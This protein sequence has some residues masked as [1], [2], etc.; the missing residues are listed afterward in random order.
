MSSSMRETGPGE[1]KC[2][3]VFNPETFDGGV[4]K[5]L[6][7]GLLGLNPHSYTTKFGLFSRI[8]QIDYGN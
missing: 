7:K 4:L 5:E 8:E 3:G 1:G 2:A 6:R